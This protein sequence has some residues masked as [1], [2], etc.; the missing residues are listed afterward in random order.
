MA[1]AK[2]VIHHMNR[3]PQGLRDKGA[4]QLDVMLRPDPDSSN[5]VNIALI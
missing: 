3:F 1:H 4:E 5:G 2:H